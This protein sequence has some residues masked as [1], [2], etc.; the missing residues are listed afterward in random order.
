MAECYDCARLPDGERPR[1][2]RKT[3]G[4]PRRPRCA[5]HKRDLKRSTK[6]GRQ[7]TYQERNFGLTPEEHAALLEYQGGTCYICRYANG[8]TKAL[9]TDHDH[10]CCPEGTSCGQCV[11]AKLCGPDNQDLIGRIEYVARRNNERPTDTLL[12]IM[13]FFEDPPMARVRRQLELSKR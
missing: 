9:A 4:A 5:T 2:F 3:D 12:R 13:G 10:A 6:L 8:S 11:R 1:V 7:A